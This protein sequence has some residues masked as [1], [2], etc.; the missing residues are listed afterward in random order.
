MKDKNITT[1]LAAPDIDRALTRLAHEIVEKNSR[2]EDVCLVGI[3]RRGSTLAQRIGHKI[4]ER[5]DV[6]PPV[7]ELDIS[8]WRDDVPDDRNN[9]DGHGP[10]LPFSVQG[11]QVIIIDDVLFTGRTVRAAMDGLITLGRPESIQLAVLLDRGHRELPI[12]PDY[13]GKNI[14]TPRQEIVEVRLNEDDGYEEVTIRKS[15]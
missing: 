5:F 1:I 2:M 4:K 13:V 3:R 12:R 15:A 6:A 8:P 11:K 7:G 10:S 14:P 9:T